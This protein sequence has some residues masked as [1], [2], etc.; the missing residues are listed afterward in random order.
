MIADEECLSSRSSRLALSEASSATIN[1][2]KVRSK[3]TE[4]RKM[5]GNSLTPGTSF[6]ETRNEQH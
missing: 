1:D 2:S 5:K 4:N 6:E 3:N